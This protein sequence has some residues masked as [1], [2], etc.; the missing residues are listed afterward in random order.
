[1]AVEPRG[2]LLLECVEGKMG[3]LRLGPVSMPLYSSAEISAV[4]EMLLVLRVPRI[5][6]HATGEAAGIRF[7]PSWCELVDLWIDDAGGGVKKPHF[8]VEP[9]LF[10]VIWPG[11]TIR[12]MLMNHSNLTR[13]V[14]VVIEGDGAR[15]M[16]WKK[17]CPSAGCASC[18]ADDSA[19]GRRGGRGDPFLEII[20]TD[21]RGPQFVMPRL[22][23]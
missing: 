23:R 3:L 7:N 8:E 14:G 15:L 10:G 19:R 21:G 9:G 5:E 12:A 22:G 20:G 17:D 1:M 11:Q 2:D 6:A 13:N 18:K 16:H 4:S